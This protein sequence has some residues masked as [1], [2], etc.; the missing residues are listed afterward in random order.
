MNPAT[1]IAIILIA[2]C[3]SGLAYGDFSYT[4]KTTGVKLGLIKLKVQEKEMVNVALIVNAS[5]ISIAV[6]L[7]DTVGRN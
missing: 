4:K 2:A 6:I 5:G 7:L 3:G 1:V